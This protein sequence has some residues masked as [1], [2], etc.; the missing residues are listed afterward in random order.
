ME[1]VAR[2]VVV[3]LVAVILLVASSVQAMDDQ[4]STDPHVRPL[5]PCRQTLVADAIRLS[6]TVHDLVA[7]LEQSDLVVYVRC[8][9]FK[10]STFSGRLSFLGATANRRYVVAEIKLY[11]QFSL[12][13]ATL[14]HELQHAKEVADAPSI[15]NTASMAAHYR[16][17]G[18][19][20]D[21]YPLIF[22]TWAA[23]AVSERVHREL[24]TLSARPR[25]AETTAGSR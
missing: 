12:Q 19:T 13:I 24:F 22:E 8:A 15:R 20:I 18:I 16:R 25:A 14:A 4:P 9:V 3:T 17:I 2:R 23:R 5:E 11:D 21:R 6:P 1:T 10:N 7:R